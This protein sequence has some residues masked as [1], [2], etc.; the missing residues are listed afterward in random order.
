MPVRGLVF[1]G[2]DSYRVSDSAERRE[3]VTCPIRRC[4]VH[5]DMTKW[6]R[7]TGR[8]DC[9]GAKRLLVSSWNIGTSAYIELQVTAWLLICMDSANSG[10]KGR[11]KIE[12]PRTNR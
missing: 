6:W 5:G 7:I 10:A 8:C 9:F 11:L 12:D 2:A 3:Y 1:I 4:G